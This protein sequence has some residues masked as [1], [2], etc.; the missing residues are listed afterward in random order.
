MVVFWESTI[1]L[2]SCAVAVVVRAVVDVNGEVVV[3]TVGVT[4]VVPGKIVVVLL[5]V[6]VVYGGLL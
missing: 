5:A 6:E 2:W 3:L 4:V 1:V